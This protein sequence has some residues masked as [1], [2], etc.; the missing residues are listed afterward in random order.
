MQLWDDIIDGM[1]PVQLVVTFNVF[2]LNILCN[3]FPLGK[4][5]LINFKNV[6]PIFALTL[7]EYGGVN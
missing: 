5:F 6:L 3:G 1:L 4:R 2:L 7:I